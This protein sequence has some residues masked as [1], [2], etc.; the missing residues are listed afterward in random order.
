[1]PPC[2]VMEMKACSICGKPTWPDSTSFFT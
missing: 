1:L 2:E